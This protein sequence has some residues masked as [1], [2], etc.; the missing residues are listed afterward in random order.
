MR[1]VLGRSGIGVSAAGVGTWAIGGAMASGDQP[2]GWGEVDD[3]ESVRAL[4]R[5]VELGATFVDTAD[6]YGTGHAERVLARALGAQRDELV[7]ATKWGNTY[8]EATRQLTGAD[9]APDY[10]RQALEASLRRLGTDRVD[11]WQLHLSD[12]DP[13]LAEDLVAT[14]EDL[15]AEGKVRAYGWS[16]DDP[17]RAAVFAA[18]PHC[19]AVQHTLNVL[20]DAPAML[21]LCEEHDLASVDRSPLAM[22][23]LSERVTADTVIAPGD[24]RHRQPEWLRWFAGGRP[25]PDFLARR[26]AVRDV[27]T[28]GGRTLA[29]GALAWA[30]ARS[31]R[32]VPIP[33]CR[34]VAQ[35]EENVGAMAHGPLTP[36]QFAEVESVLR[37][38]GREAAAAG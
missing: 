4:R 2:L 35:V 33:G 11:L 38:A 31:P 36:E 23:L 29:Q 24:V 27:L 37:P 12:L 7:W 26:D 6:V 14:C 22:G 13:A 10:A 28:S 9:P 1:R 8:E 18:G 30:W 15:V 5:A 17:A 20:D 34:T 21:A 25:S 32:T 19:A 3:D 16:T